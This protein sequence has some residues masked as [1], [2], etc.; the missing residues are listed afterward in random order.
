MI[1][2]SN[3]VKVGLYR[4]R[5]IALGTGH[6]EY[7]SK[8]ESGCTGRGNTGCYVDMGADWKRIEQE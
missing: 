7:G 5:D 2:I 6:M 4:V 3:L 1:E 8:Q